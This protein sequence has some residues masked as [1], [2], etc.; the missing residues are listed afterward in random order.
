MRQV[1]FQ[2]VVGHDVVAEQH[3]GVARVLAAHQ[4]V[5]GVHGVAGEGEV[6]PRAHHL[7]LAARAIHLGPGDRAQRQAEPHGRRAH[8]HGA[9][10]PRVQNGAHGAAVDQHRQHDAVVLQ[11]RVELAVG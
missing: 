6:H 8:D 10:R 5:D 11:H 9:L 4:H 7:R 1:E 2:V 3:V